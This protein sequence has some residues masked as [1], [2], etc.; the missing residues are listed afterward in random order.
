[1]IEKYRRFTGIKH[2]NFYDKASDIDS[3]LKAIIF[4]NNLHIKRWLGVELSNSEKDI[5][6]E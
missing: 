4:V 5:L 1:M 6:T 2:L 3:D